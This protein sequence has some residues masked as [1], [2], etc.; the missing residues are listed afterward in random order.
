MIR[1]RKFRILRRRQ[2]VR[3]HSHVQLLFLGGARA[4]CAKISVVEEIPDPYTN[5]T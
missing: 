5:R 3:S 2:L 4:E 1:R